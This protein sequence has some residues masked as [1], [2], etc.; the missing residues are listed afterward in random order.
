VI[1]NIFNY[2]IICYLSLSSIWGQTYFN[3]S[4]EIPPS[5]EGANVIN[6]QLIDNK[7]YAGVLHFNGPILATSI[8]TVFEDNMDVVTIADIACGLDCL[9]YDGDK[10]FIHGNFNLIDNKISLMKLDWD[11]NP[12]W[13]QSFHLD[14]DFASNQ[15]AKIVG[16]DVFLFSWSEFFEG[17]VNGLTNL[18]KLDLDGKEIWSKDYGQENRINNPWDLAIDESDCLYTATAIVE[19]GDNN[20]RGEIKKLNENGEVLWS[21]RLIEFLPNGASPV[22]VSVLSNGNLVAHGERD[23]VEGEHNYYREPPIIYILDQEGK[24]LSDT[25]L[26]NNNPVELT[27]SE[28]ISGRGEYFFAFG[29]EVHWWD[30]EFWGVIFKFNND[31]ELIWKRKYQHPDFK[32][33]PLLLTFQIDDLIELESGEIISIG[34]I[35]TFSSN[36]SHLWMMRL[37]QDGCLSDNNCG[38][39]V[40]TSTSEISISPQLQVRIH[41]ENENISVLSDYLYDISTVT[42]YDLYGHKIQTENCSDDTC[43]FKLNINNSGIY[44]VNVKFVDGMRYSEKFF[45][46]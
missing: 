22:Y 27:F 29:H 35:N 36:T 2:I 34:E 25:T 37:S 12:E 7:I 15:R 41:L 31:G 16:D 42:I 14:G 11:L 30:N 39:E 17:P 5:L 3:A 8:A 18:R 19:Q 33:D 40:I 46:N 44:I 45:K 28:I 24:I 6:G 1:K 4:Y 32:E 20:A 13:H 9:M 10:I 21:T 26:L 38:E 43:D 23:L